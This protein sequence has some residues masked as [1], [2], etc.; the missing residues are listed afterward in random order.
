MRPSRFW[1]HVFRIGRKVPKKTSEVEIHLQ[2]ASGFLRI[3]S[4][5]LEE[6][7]TNVA[8]TLAI[9]SAIRSK[10]A[11]CVFWFGISKHGHDHLGAKAE[12]RRVPEIGKKLET[13]FSRIAAGKTDAEYSATTVSASLAVQ[14][15]ERA[16]IMFDLV[17]RQ[18]FS[19]ARS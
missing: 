2:H 5:A 13:L 14:T 1:V 11:I 15:V 7:E 9:N 4:I 18:I 10:D 6:G 16:G 12:L 19:S 8:A 17:H 3:S